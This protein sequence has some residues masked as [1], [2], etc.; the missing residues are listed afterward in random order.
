MAKY[1]AIPLG[2]AQTRTMAWLIGH[3]AD[4]RAE[5]R[6]RRSGLVLT[7]TPTYFNKKVKTMQE[8]FQ[9]SEPIQ[10][11]T[12]ESIREVLQ[13][14][15][16]LVS[17]FNDVAECKEYVKYRPKNSVIL[18]IFDP[19]ADDRNI[20]TDFKKES[21][22]LVI[23]CCVS[24]KRFDALFKRR[25]FKNHSCFFHKLRSIGNN[26]S[27]QCM[28]LTSHHIFS[29]L[30]ITE[31]LSRIPRPAD[32]EKDFIEFCKS[33]YE[34]DANY[35]QYERD[36]QEFVADSDE[37]KALKWYTKSKNFFSLLINE[38]CIC[39]DYRVLPK[40]G[41]FLYDIYQQLKKLHNEQLGNRLKSG[42]TVFR[43]KSVSMDELNELKAEGHYFI[44]RNMLSASIDSNVAQAFNGKD[45]RSDCTDQSVLLTF[46]LDHI[47]SEQQP[48]AFIDEVSH[49]DQE[50][51]LLFP[52]GVVFRLQSYTSLEINGEHMWKFEMIRG[53]E[54]IRIEKNLNRQLPYWA[55]T[56]VKG[57][58]T[59]ICNVQQTGPSGQEVI[60]PV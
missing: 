58:F 17:E 26:A 13:L 28:D 3:D 59:P 47:E 8:H 48:V 12:K 30:F 19:Y 50:G 2:N 4:I 40:I 37:I 56:V 39:L 36:M 54:E 45:A 52:M 14:N 15:D 5:R 10:L 32:V 53:E 25:I 16:T 35:P 43:G 20:V 44:T 6:K 31:L 46:Q 1:E 11:Q 9:F 55:E 57:L 29:Y 60:Q 49:F 33:K 51:E 22:I 7:P 21:S 38:A 24:Q 27:L 42:L 18:I 34:N 41:F 23:Y